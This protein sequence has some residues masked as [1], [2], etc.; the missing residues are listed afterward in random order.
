MKKKIFSILTSVSLIAS[1]LGTGA[2][3][4]PS[5]FTIIDSEISY[6]APESTVESP[7]NTDSFVFSEGPSPV[8]M[9]ESAKET[10]TIFGVPEIDEGAY[11]FSELLGDGTQENPFL[12][13]TA[14]ELFT[15]AEYI[16]SGLYANAYYKLTGNIDLGGAE[17]A[18]MGY[19]SGSGSETDYSH[20]FGGVLDGDGY[21]ISNFTITKNTTAYIGLFGFIH[22]GTV[23]NLNLDSLNISF[24][25]ESKEKLYVSPV[26]G[27]VVSDEENMISR[28][29][30]CH[31]TNTVVNVSSLGFVY[32]GG[33]IGGANA[34]DVKGAEIFLAFSST[35]CHISVSTSSTETSQLLAAA[36]GIAGY[37]GAQTGSKITA[38]NCHSYSTVEAH[39]P[40]LKAGDN[41]AIA[42]SGGVFGN[43]RTQEENIALTGGEM[44]IS[45]CYSTGDVLSTADFNQYIAGGFAAQVLP[46]KLTKIID[47]YSSSDVTGKFNNY[48]YIYHEGLN[49]LHIDPVAGGFIGQIFYYLYTPAYGKDIVNCYASGD[50]IDLV[51]NETSLKDTS[52]V[53]GFVA[54][55]DA[56]TYENCFR[57]ESQVRNGSDTCE[58]DYFDILVLSDESSLIKDSYTGYDFVNVWQMDAEA[59][60][61]Y[62]T[63]KEKSGYV[64][65]V[66]EGNSYSIASFGEDGKIS[67]PAQNPVKSASV[68]KVFTFSYW[69][70]SENG[71]EFSF[72]SDTVSENTTLYAVYSSSPR[73]Y[74]LKFISE[75]KSFVDDKKLDYGSVINAPKKTIQTNSTTDS[76]TG[77][78]VKTEMNTTFPTQSFTAIRH[79]MRCLTKSTNLHGQAALQTASPQASAQRHFPMLLHQATNLLSLQSLSTKVPKAIERL[80]TSLVQTYTLATTSGYR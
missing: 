16:N 33:L 34:G 1:A 36:G 66:S 52:F 68:D 38:I 42:M 8:M 10:N 37:F 43:L 79:S 15:M 18:P 11:L 24:A 27:R 62:P 31:V 50:V 58:D 22:G 23:K 54:Y 59:E 65:F 25:S 30:N 69:S 63:L 67:A 72:E 28:I 5:A 80:T 13:G 29:E 7:E 60:Y 26:S 53:G 74:T 35:D 3:A 64:T 14:N 47:C 19:V 55:S 45:S 44:Y 51:H 40:E 61:P 41:L 73:Q 32:A 39:A 76:S 48:G 46:T 20:S 2:F 6:T 56:S 21:T 77:R 12:V 75:G 4:A 49:E 9:F 78:T 71:V 70:L 17:W 57:F